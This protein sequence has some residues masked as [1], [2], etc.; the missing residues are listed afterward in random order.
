MLE[1]YWRN[2]HCYKPAQGQ[3]HNPSLHLYNR[4]TLSIGI[5]FRP[6]DIASFQAQVPDTSTARATTATVRVHW[7]L[8][9]GGVRGPSGLLHV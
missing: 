9:S 3:L 5:H 1:D 4:A 6:P 2:R 8:A 7:K